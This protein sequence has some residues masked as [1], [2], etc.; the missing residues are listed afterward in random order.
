MKNIVL[1][2]FKKGEKSFGTF[3]TIK[4]STAIEALGYTG[5]DFV[6]IDT[7][8]TPVSTGEA[9]EYISAAKI[10]GLTSFVRTKGVSRSSI[11]RFLDAG[12]QALVIPCIESVDQVK[13][14]ISYAKY[15]P[16]GNRGFCPTK[17]GGW[18]YGEHAQNGIESYM[19]YCNENTLLLP[20]CETLGC[21]DNIEEIVG[22]EGVDGILIGPFDLSIAMGKPAQFND[23]EVKKAI[24]RI[25]K[26]CKKFNKIAFIFTGSTDDANKYFKDGFDCVGVGL[27][28][29]TYI[30]AYR[31]IVSKIDK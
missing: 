27:D 9:S 14:I 29:A 22:I 12:A 21:L 30:N 25:L 1:E 3:T 16:L 5:L 17:D 15:Y 26:A 18:G 2:K 13:E 28:T 8:H 24:D 19:N 31:E 10:A 4:S 23:P 7:E 6:V 11:L 20:Q